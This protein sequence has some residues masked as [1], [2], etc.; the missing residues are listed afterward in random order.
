MT[1]FRAVRSAASGGSS[2]DSLSLAEALRTSRLS[3]KTQLGA[4][5][6]P[7]TSYRVGGSAAALV[8]VDTRDELNVLCGLLSSTDRG[9]GAAVAVIGRGSNLLVSDDG[10]DGVAVTLGSGFKEVRIS[11]VTVVAGGSAKLPV[12]ARASVS[13]ALSGLEWAVGV[14]GSVGGAVRMNAGGHGAEMKDSLVAAELVDLSTG[15]CR[16]CSNNDLEFGYRT[17][18]VIASELVLDARFELSRG[19]AAVG[20]A[21]LAE[22][23]AWRRAN[24]PVGRNAGSVFA[25]PDGDSAG[26]LIES[27]G[28][29]GLR[30]GTAE[31]SQK[32]ANFIQVD[33]NGRS[34]DVLSLMK[35]IQRRVLE[36]HGIDLAAETKLLGFTEPGI[37]DDEV[38][39]R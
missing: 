33:E 8:V 5:L 3:A 23:V 10:F 13:A 6:G 38:D 27:V 36:H 4:P 18:S 16:L 39:S 7:L 32:H 1:G 25:N 22:I 20:K 19:D 17:S 30:I 14:P 37:A 2:E 26:R 9:A 15:E 35:E 12:V 28:A 11:G 31:V 24:Q 34:A 21:K 29:K